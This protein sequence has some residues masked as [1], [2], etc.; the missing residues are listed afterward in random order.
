MGSISVSAGATQRVADVLAAY[1]GAQVAMLVGSDA[2]YAEWGAELISAL[3]DA[4]AS[5]VSLAGKP[6][7][8]DVDDSCA[9]GD[10]ALAFLVRTREALR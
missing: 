1:D 4:G 6:R 9:L 5:R 2:S 7:D 8:L 10:D 3:R